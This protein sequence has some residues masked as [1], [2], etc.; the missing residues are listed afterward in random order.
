ML[1][2]TYTWVERSLDLAIPKVKL[3][4]N[5]FSRAHI[6]W[7]ITIF[8]T[9]PSW[10]LRIPLNTAW[11]QPLPSNQNWLT[12]E[13]DF[14]SLSYVFFS[15]VCIVQYFEK[16]HTE[17]SSVCRVSGIRERQFFTHLLAQLFHG[18]VAIWQGGLQ[19]GTLGAHFSFP[20]SY[21]WWET[22]QGEQFTGIIPRPGSI[23]K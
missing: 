10:I 14:S 16:E 1:H 19:P 4:N 23:M 13:T 8:S 20:L 11:S 21:K 17:L 22:C 2:S 18:G 9:V 15:A 12:A 5:L 6:A 3:Q 7:I